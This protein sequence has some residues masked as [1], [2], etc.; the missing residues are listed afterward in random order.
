[1][2]ESVQAGLPDV[3][4]S[5]PMQPALPCNTF[6]SKSCMPL[7]LKFFVWKRRISGWVFVCIADG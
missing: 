7:D 6:R 1:M 4:G 5:S 3:G 2:F